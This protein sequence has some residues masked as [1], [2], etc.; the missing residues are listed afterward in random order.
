MRHY[1]ANNGG[2]DLGP[3]LLM[4]AVGLALVAVFL[5]TAFLVANTILN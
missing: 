3:A 5:M 1:G 4:L 2:N